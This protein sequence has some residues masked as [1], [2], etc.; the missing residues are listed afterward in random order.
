MP[1]QVDAMRRSFYA[2][3]RNKKKTADIER[4]SEYAGKLNDEADAQYKARINGKTNLKYLEN[5]RSLAS[6]LEQR[7]GGISNPVVSPSP[8][9]WM[10]D[11]VPLELYER[12]K[13]VMEP[14]GIV[15]H[16]VW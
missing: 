6:K 8:L 14:N 2:K 5:A 11:A 15:S 13:D 7:P 16:D 4:I 9:A 10:S 12:N 1:Q 3:G